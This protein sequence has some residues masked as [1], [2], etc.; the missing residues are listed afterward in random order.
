MKKYFPLIL[1][2]LMATT[3]PTSRSFLATWRLVC[4]SAS[5]IISRTSTI[6]LSFGDKTKAPSQETHSTSYLALR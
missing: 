3:A 1:M 6:G 4:S 5:P 2:A